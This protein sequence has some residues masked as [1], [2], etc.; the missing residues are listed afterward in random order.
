VQFTGSLKGVSAKDAEHLVETLKAKVAADN[1][2]LERLA[3]YV[4]VVTSVLLERDPNLLVEINRKRNMPKS[5]QVQPKGVPA[6]AKPTSLK[7][8]GKK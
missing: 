8:P 4:D 2:E 5:P 3:E 1:V 7:P 6:T